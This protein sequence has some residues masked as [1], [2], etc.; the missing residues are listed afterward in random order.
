M[1]ETERPPPAPDTGPGVPRWMR[2]VGVASWYFIGFCGAVALLALV[3]AASRDIV[4]PLILG[5]LFAVVRPI[6]GD[7]RLHES[8]GV[9]FGRFLDFDNT[10]GAFEPLLASLVDGISSLHVNQ[11]HHGSMLQRVLSR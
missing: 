10:R 9:S 5:V 1:M 6:A 11:W 8:E 7:D 4:I 2:R 3:F